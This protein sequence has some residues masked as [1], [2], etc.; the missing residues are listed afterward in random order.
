MRKCN[1]KLMLFLLFRS[2][3]LDFEKEYK[4]IGVSKKRRKVRCL[5]LIARLIREAKA[6]EDYAYDAY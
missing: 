2:V 1:A 3:R 5:E 6:I 4:K